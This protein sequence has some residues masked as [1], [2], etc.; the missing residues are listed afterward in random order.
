MGG[1]LDAAMMERRGPTPPRSPTPEPAARH[2]ADAK[3][4]R[5]GRDEPAE[6][7]GEGGAADAHRRKRRKHSRFVSHSFELHG[8]LG[9]WSFWMSGS[10][11]HGFV[12]MWRAGYFLAH[13]VY[14]VEASV[15]VHIYD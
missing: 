5:P 10:G 13:Q 2:R 15:K 11:L 7:P 3:R 6:R 14:I 9:L 1:R 12:H 8:F 4:H